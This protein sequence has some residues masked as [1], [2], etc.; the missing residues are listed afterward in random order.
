MGVGDQG[1]LVNPN[2]LM[3]ARHAATCL[4]EWLAVEAPKLTDIVVLDRT[5]P[6][7]HGAR[8]V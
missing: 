4:R 8:A 1:D 6:A 3:S 2:A 5:W 7:H